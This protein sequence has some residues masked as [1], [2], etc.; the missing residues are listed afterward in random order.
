MSTKKKTG[1]RTKGT[2][3]KRNEAVRETLESMACDPIAGMATIAHKAF[4]RRDYAL[5]GNMYKEL[6]KYVAPQLKAVEV[7]GADGEPLGP[8]FDP[9]K[10]AAEFTNSILERLNENDEHTEETDED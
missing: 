9:V 5:A 10:A 1:G 2:G 6:A 7:T 4:I 3:N 8:D